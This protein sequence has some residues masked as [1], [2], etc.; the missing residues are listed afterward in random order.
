MPLDPN[1]LSRNELVQLVNS[2]SLG[3]CLTRGRLSSQ[4]N[5]AGRRWH[6]GRHVRLLDY[7]RWLTREVERPAR[8]RI[9]G[10]TADLARKNTETWRSQNVAPVP[11]VVDPARRQHARESFRFFCET[12]FAAALYRNWS[13]DHLRVIDKI[14]RAVKEGGLFAFAMPRGSG[15]TTL[16][17]L[18]ALWAVLAGYRPF[19]CLIGGSQERAI[20][21]LTPIR[22]AI[23]EN[24]LLLDD[25]PKAIH[26]L[27]RLQNNA[28][29]QIG[30]HIDGKPTYCTWASDKLVF[31]TV[32]GSE[33]SGAI[34]AVTSLDANMR[35]QQHTM[36]DGRT[37]RPSLVLLDDPQT[38]QSARSP[39]Q[40]RYR[41]QL[42]TGDVLGMAGP[43]ES[44]AAVLTCTKI[45][46]GDQA[47]QILDRQKNPEWQ[48]ECTKLVYAFPTAEKLW[49]E[50]ARIRAEGLRTG[51]GLAPASQFYV[52]R[53]QAMDAG[54]IVAWSERF[55]PKTEISAVQ[56]AMNLK[57]RDEEAFAAEYQNEPVTEQFEDERLSA[58]E[59]AEKITGRPRGEVPLAATRVT[60]FIDVHDK[61]LFW[62]VCA[63]EEDF[64]GYVIDYGT[65][66]DQKRLYFTLRDATHT[67]AASFH[68]AGKEGAVQSG[69]EKLS[70]ELLARTWERTDGMALHVE[71]L[72][73]DSGYLPGV[74]NAVAIKV[75]PAVLLSKGMG[76]KA[77]N[78]PM[79]AYTRRPGERHGHN[80]YIPNVS[81][82]SEFRHVAFDANS[83]KTF[84]HARL[85]T[86][87]GDRGAMT[88][89]GKKPEQ[90]R[91]FAEH[92]ADA[93]SYVVTEGQGRT[94]HEWR[95]KP[96]KPDNHW[97]DCLVGCAVAASMAGVKAPGETAAGRQRK[98][99]TQADL[100][101]R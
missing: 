37:L 81:R 9:D 15:K 59:V 74:C 101:R 67:L 63:W 86:T 26:P 79:A 10:R 35:G 65:F 7:L 3:E 47:D 22:K 83:W 90:H 32:E 100:Q 61:L 70:S 14:E 54:A 12:Y 28:R 23:L 45:Y 96:S 92:V 1:K 64:T 5:R 21:L 11:A 40:T 16:A 18:S 68:G 73:I 71:R 77:G 94:V 80:W 29:R 2:T 25:F 46:A 76:L 58:D 27:R 84:V 53:R 88:L 66:P 91:L 34:I 52:A 50:Y 20:E 87:T 55:D 19:V 56:H 89:F 57:L 95:P 36:M 13:E 99:Y 38:R 82:S 33:S 62:C 17:R 78:K 41:L 69:L 48:G 8:P 49:D 31:P 39:S 24:P 4:M 93:E 72:L 85:A 75:G 51:K 30:Q 60:A 44:I 43:G 97:L 98:R 42:L 6:D